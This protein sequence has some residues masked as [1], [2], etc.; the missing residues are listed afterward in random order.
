VEARVEEILCLSD[1]GEG[2]GGQQSGLGL[3][4]G[5]GLADDGPTDGRTF[6]ENQLAI[7]AG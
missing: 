6:R 4:P 7:E 3:K 5:N 1:P 2:H